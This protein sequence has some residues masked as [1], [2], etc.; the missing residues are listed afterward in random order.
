MR[1]KLVVLL[2]NAKAP[3]YLTCGKVFRVDMEM[4][5][6][7]SGVFKLFDVSLTDFGNFSFQMTKASFSY[8]TVLRSLNE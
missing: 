6:M 2:A 1:R 3:S 7:V 4:L 8:F 5:A